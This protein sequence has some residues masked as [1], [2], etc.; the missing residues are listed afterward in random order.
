[1]IWIV[2]W[3]VV[4]NLKVDFFAVVVSFMQGNLSGS[5]S[6]DLTLFFAPSSGYITY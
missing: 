3:Y 5:L 2:V 1:V 6:S 4:E